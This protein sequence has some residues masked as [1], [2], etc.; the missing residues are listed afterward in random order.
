MS[1]SQDVVY[2][3]PFEEGYHFA[4]DGQVTALIL[5]M[6]AEIMSEALAYSKSDWRCFRRGAL[7]ALMTDQPQE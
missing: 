6:P 5:A 2:I 7:K 3:D 4:K 1:D